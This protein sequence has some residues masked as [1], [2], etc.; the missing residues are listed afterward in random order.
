MSRFFHIFRQI[1]VVEFVS[2]NWLTPALLKPRELVSRISGADIGDYQMGRN[3]QVVG[4]I[5]GQ[6]SASPYWTIG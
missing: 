3:A 6:A 5:E 4:K 2:Y 1:I